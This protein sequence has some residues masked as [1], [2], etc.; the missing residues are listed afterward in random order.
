[1]IKQQQGVLIKYFYLFSF[2][3]LSPTVQAQSPDIQLD[4][5]VYDFGLIK[6]TGGPVYHK[7]TFTNNGSSA[8]S[9]DTVEA[10]CGCTVPLWQKTA[11]APGESSMIKLVYYPYKRPGAFTKSATIRVSSNGEQAVRFVNIKGNVVREDMEASL[12]ASMQKA[13]SIQY[14]FEIA[15][16]LHQLNFS[17]TPIQLKSSTFNTFI[18]DLTYIIDQD[19]YVNIELSAP[20]YKNKYYRDSVLPRQFMDVQKAIETAFAYRGYEKHQVAFKQH[21]QRI[22]PWNWPEAISDTRILTLRATDYHNGNLTTSVIEEIG[23][24]GDAPKAEETPTIDTILFEPGLSAYVREP[25]TGKK[26]E[27]PE[28]AYAKFVRVSQREILANG[29]VQLQLKVTQTPAEANLSKSRAQATD[30]VADLEKSLRKELKKTGFNSNQLLFHTAQYRIY[31]AALFSEAQRSEY[32]FVQVSRLFLDEEKSLELRKAVAARIE[33]KTKPTT[34]APAEILAAQ[35]VNEVVE[36]TVPEEPKNLYFK[37]QTLP[38]C[39][40]FISAK[41]ARIDTTDPTFITMINLVIAELKAG[42][43]INFMVESSASKA[44][45][46][47][48]HFSNAYV[49]RIRGK[50]S[51]ELI[52]LYL[53]NSGIDDTLIHFREG[54]NL[55]QGPEFNKRHYLPE[56][57]EQYQ[58][59]KVIPLYDNGYEGS[60]TKAVTPY[61]VN[62]DYNST[63]LNT[64]GIGYKVFIKKLMPVM[65]DQGYVKLIIESSA[66]KVPTE[67]HRH[68]IVL[69]FDRAEDARQKIYNSMVANGVDPQR[70]IIVE[71][72]TLVQGPAYEKGLDRSLPTYTDH[73]YIKIIPAAIITGGQ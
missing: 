65:R 64:A 53:E 46:H 25:Y 57:Y 59:V 72:R 70:V 55:V 28:E 73:Q 61:M 15:P 31:D 22:L 7:F 50:E 20:T 40:T 48:H 27:W 56:F 66:S 21:K 4:A 9:V 1:L 18:N 51:E 11:I 58:Y 47:Y 32:N 33:G 44:P 13:Q 69:A 19:G 67:S 36:N 2:L 5:L 30:L 63:G 60:G 37:E 52:A 42:E 17:P 62:F 24:S 16:Y 23:P 29:F 43:K 34:A 49:A 71:E 68:S 35:N 14:Q 6:E 41:Y 54:V 8:V 39:K 10:S 45:T 3:I 12:P 26:F 38:V